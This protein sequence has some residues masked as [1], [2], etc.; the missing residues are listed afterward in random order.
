MWKEDIMKNLESESLSYATVGEFLSDLKEEFDGGDDEIIKMAELKKMEQESKT[1]EEFIQE[2]RRM[3]RRSR[4]KRQPLIEEFKGE[5]NGVIRRKFIEIE[6]PSRSIDK[7]YKCTTNL[8]R[9]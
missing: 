3:T 8:D 6:R 5:M 4:Y 2:L 1:I 9:H 7:W